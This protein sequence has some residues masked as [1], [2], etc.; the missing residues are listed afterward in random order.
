MFTIFVIAC[1]IA[2]IVLSVSGSRIIS[3]TQQRY[4]VIS[5]LDAV[6]VICH[7]IDDLVLGEI[8]WFVM[9][10]IDIAHSKKAQ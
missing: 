8:F 10:C 7:A 5:L 9:L 6:L 4:T 2:N 1:I 3:S